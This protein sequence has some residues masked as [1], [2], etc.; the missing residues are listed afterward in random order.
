[1]NNDK[2]ALEIAGKKFQLPGIKID[3]IVQKT[4]STQVSR[5]NG[6]AAIPV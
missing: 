4:L 5:Q 3:R 6:R 1:M 2:R